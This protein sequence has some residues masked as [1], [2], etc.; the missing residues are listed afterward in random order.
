MKILLYED[1]RHDR[2]IL[3]ARISNFLSG[4]KFKYSIDECT[5]PEMLMDIVCAYDFLFI[6][7]ELG[8]ENGIDLGIKAKEKHKDCHVVITSNYTKYLIDGYKVKADR[9]LLKPVSQA[10]F[11]EEMAPVFREY[12]AENTTIYDEKIS[13]YR[14]R[15]SDIVY[16]DFCDKNAYL[17][18]DN[19]KKLKTPYPLYYWEEKLAK[20]SFARC[21]KSILV[22]L[23]YV[24]T[25][26]KNDILLINK[27]KIP[28]SRYYRKQFEQKWL[29]NIQRMI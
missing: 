5:S 22:N 21:Y 11:D 10:Q 3:K 26:V 20:D 8:S 28:V 14:I 19:G 6:D 1:D 27:Q 29:E 23:N 15:L 25:I 16:I 13:R 9:Y 4:H 18:F 7:I 24:D 2:E 12:Y 17:V